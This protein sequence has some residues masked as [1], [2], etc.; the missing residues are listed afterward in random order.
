MKTVVKT[1]Q[2]TITDIAA[3]VGM[4]RSGV[5]YAIDNLKKENAL[6]RGGSAKKGT[7]VVADEG[8]KGMDGKVDRKK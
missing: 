6:R 1:P 7:W 5:Q 4:S 3:S 2:V 8:I